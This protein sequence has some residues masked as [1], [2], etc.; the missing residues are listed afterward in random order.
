ME[1]ALAVQP[2]SKQMSGFDKYFMNLTLQ[3]EQVNPWF[4]EFWREYHKCGRKV[5]TEI[6]QT[7]EHVSN[8]HSSLTTPKRIIN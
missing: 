2:L 5:I 7:F 4:R 6:N 1:G 3:H 8:F